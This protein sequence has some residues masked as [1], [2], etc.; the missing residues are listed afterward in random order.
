MPSHLEVMAELASTSEFAALFASI[1][2]LR[3]GPKVET[4]KLDL[5]VGGPNPIVATSPICLQLARAFLFSL[6]HFDSMGSKGSPVCGITFILIPLSER[7]AEALS[8]ATT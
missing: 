4:S 1:S 7:V 6:E 8:A 5:E 3:E 2:E